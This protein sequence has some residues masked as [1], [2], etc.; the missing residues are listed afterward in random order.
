MV[1]YLSVI[2]LTLSSL[3]TILSIVAILIVTSNHAVI[4]HLIY[5]KKVFYG[6]TFFA[7]VM[8]I[9]TLSELLHETHFYLWLR[10][11]DTILITILTIYGLLWIW[12]MVDR[13]ILKLNRDFREII[14]SLTVFWMFWEEAKN[15]VSTK[16]IETLTVILDLSAIPL[17][18]F[19][20][21]FASIYLNELLKGNIA[22]PMDTVPFFLGSLISFVLLNFSFINYIVKNH[23]EHY[24]FDFGAITIFLYYEIRYIFHLYTFSA[25][26]GISEN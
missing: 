12:R 16:V 24:V 19:L 1:E 7:I 18:I 17:S 3:S 5:S 4:Q 23:F 6:I 26:G 21:I 20:L 2:S 25:S 9:W 10:L 13:P 15:Y 22:V 8:V 11:L 14:L